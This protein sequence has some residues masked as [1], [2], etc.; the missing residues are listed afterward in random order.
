MDDEV[1]ALKVVIQLR[2]GVNDGKAFQFLNL[3]AHFNIRKRAGD[4]L[5]RTELVIDNLEQNRAN[6]RSE[7]IR[8]QIDWVFV[9]QI[10]IFNGAADEGL[11]GGECV[12]CVVCI[13][14]IKSV[15]RV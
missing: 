4:E 14:D 2:D 13:I 8:M 10:K 3:P 1:R 9:V 6:P 7:C 15:S 12:A 5:Y 11:E